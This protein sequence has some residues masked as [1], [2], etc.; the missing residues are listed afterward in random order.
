MPTPAAPRIRAAR[1]DDW[2]AITEFNQRLARETEGRALDPAILGRGVQQ[3]LR[4][5]EACRYFLAEV[6]GELAGQTMVTTEWSDWRCGWF[7]WIQSVYVAEQFRGQGVYRALHRNIEALALAAGD[8][9]GLRLYV[10]TGNRRA[11]ATYEKLGMTRTHYLMYERDWSGA[12][13]G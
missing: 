9:C 12:V 2:P 13:H 11:I 4:R 7:W 1:L 6:G 8:V 10:E 5:P 3:A